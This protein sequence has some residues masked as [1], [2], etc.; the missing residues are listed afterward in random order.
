[1][2]RSKYYTTVLGCSHKNIDF[3]IIIITF[4]LHVTD[5]GRVI[6]ITTKWMAF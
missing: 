3:F 2:R 4:T 6:G 1:M 5:N